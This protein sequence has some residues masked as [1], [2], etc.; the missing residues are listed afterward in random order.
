METDDRRAPIPRATHLLMGLAA[1]LLPGCGGGSPDAPAGGGQGDE[2]PAIELEGIEVAPG[3]ELVDSLPLESGALDD[4]SLLL[5]TLDTTRADRLGCY[6]NGAVETPALDRIAREGVLFSFATAVTPVTLPSHASVLTG[7]YPSSH[8]ARANGLFRLEE[9]HETLAERLSAEGLRTG[10]FVSS[11]VL[12]A[13]FGLAQGFEHYDDEL[14]REE[15][16]RRNFRTRR[17]DHTTDRALDWLRETAPER[18]FLWVHYIDPHHDYAPPSPFRERYAKNLY[19]GEIAFVDAQLRRLMEA[20]EE[21]ELTEKCLVVVVGDHGEGLGEHREGTHGYLL[22]ES[23]LRVPFLMS[24]GK[25]LGGGKHCPR[26]VSHV[27]VMPSVLELFGLG[28]GESDGVALNREAGEDRPLFFEALTGSFDYG[29]EPL[30]GVLRG[31]DKYVHSSEPELFDLTGDP[32]EERNLFAVEGTRASALREALSEHYGPNLERVAQVAPTVQPSSSDLESL[33]AL[34]YVGGGAD[35]GSASGLPRRMIALFHRVERAKSSERSL[36]ENVAGLR[37]VLDEEPDF[38]P[39]WKALGEVYVRHGEL[40]LG[41][42]AL[43]NCLR[44][45]PGTPMDV[46]GLAAIRESQGRYAEALQLLAPVLH[47]YP[48]YLRAAHLGAVVLGALGRWPEAAARFK[49]VVDRDPDYQDHLCMKQMMDAFG[50]AG[51]GGELENLLRGYLKRDPE[52][53]ETRLLLASHLRRARREE[54][55]VSVLREGVELTS[56]D[57]RVVEELA[58]L[59]AKGSNPAV[60][61]LRAAIALLEPYAE[62]GAEDPQL[63]YTL[64]TLYGATGR[65]EEALSVAR[66]ARGLASRAG[67]DELVET[68][69]QRLP[70]AAPPPAR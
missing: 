54:Q 24:C 37:A 65:V 10:A 1:I 14:P 45:K 33:Q 34:G 11:F 31:T 12:N 44:L 62:P 30:V 28:T 36:D 60:R 58:L 61:D 52:S 23:T 63:M 64:C 27:D 51:R 20:L 9:G 3:L 38:Y 46:F 47:E 17:A 35:E 68:I 18:F 25:R 22:Y 26:P 55:A 15:G 32:R 21:L 4:C 6:G 19:D 49:E 29:W 41:A 8:G 56:V 66:R 69:D 67:M 16:P 13:Q 59:L 50:K 48:G 43:S 7:L 39:A 57:P 42:E 2:G 5:V 53:T 70:G 40:E